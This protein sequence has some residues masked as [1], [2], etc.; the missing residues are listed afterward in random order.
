MQNIKSRFHNL[1]LLIP[2]LSLSPCIFKIY[3]YLSATAPVKMV[4]E[5][6][7]KAMWKKNLN[8]ASPV[9]YSLTSGEKKKF[10]NPNNG[11]DIGSDVPETIPYPK[12]QNNI[13]PKT[14]SMTFLI[15]MFT[16]F[17]KVHIPDSSKPKPYSDL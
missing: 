17:F 13:P 16:S 14:T 2:D 6:V 8:Y 12:H 3:W 7:T 4:V 1:N 11:L 5:H 9:P 15:K 10:P